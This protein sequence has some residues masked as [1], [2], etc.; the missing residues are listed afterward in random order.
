MFD[1][2]P[3]QV[4]ASELLWGM[5]NARDSKSVQ[6]IQVQTF[7]SAKM[8]NCR[9]NAKRAEQGAQSVCC[10]WIAQG[11]FLALCSHGLEDMVSC[12]RE[13]GQDCRA[14]EKAALSRERADNLA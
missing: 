12:R 6:E 14:E 3:P 11:C 10:S 8:D 1:M 7:C 2:T 9:Q 5:G 13:G 4:K